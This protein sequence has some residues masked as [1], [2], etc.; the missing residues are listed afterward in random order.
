MTDELD[1]INPPLTPVERIIADGV[2]HH[3]R[4]CEIKSLLARYPGR[5][6]RDLKDLKDGD[7]SYALFVKRYQELIAS[8]DQAYR[9]GSPATKAHE[10]MIGLDQKITEQA[11]R[12]K[13]RAVPLVEIALKKKEP[14]KR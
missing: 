14:Q 7:P 6:V 9:S 10:L 11:R 2:T 12:K 13:P 1:E 5:L 4:F 3:S 8:L